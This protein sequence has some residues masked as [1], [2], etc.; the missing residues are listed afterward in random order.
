MRHAR[1]QP[2]AVGALAI[3][4]VEP[5]L[6]ASLVL[7]AGGPHLETTGLLCAASRAVPLAMVA[8][9]T[10]GELSS[11]P[12]A[13]PASKCLHSPREVKTRQGG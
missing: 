10:Q 1:S 11:A 8:A 4:V 13:A 7:A 5:T 12:P 6:G 2:R 9:A 3:G